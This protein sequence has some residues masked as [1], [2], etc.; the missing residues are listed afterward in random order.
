[1]LNATMLMV[2]CSWYG[3]RHPALGIDV[4]VQLAQRVALTA[5]NL[6]LQAVLRR[7][8]GR[9]A[10]TSSATATQQ[11]QQELQ[12]QERQQQQ[13]EIAQDG[14]GAGCS[15]GD[16]RSGGCAGGGGSCGP[17]VERR[18]KARSSVVYAKWEGAHAE[19]R[20]AGSA[21]GVCA[22]FAAF[23]ESEG[24]PKDAPS[25]TVA[26]CA[27]GDSATAAGGAAG[28]RAGPPAR[29]GQDGRP[30][31]L[32]EQAPAHD[33]HGV[34]T[35]QS[36]TGTTC[37]VQRR[38]AR[39]TYRPHLP[40]PAANGT[41]DWVSQ[42]HTC[43]SGAPASPRR[44]GPSRPTPRYT[45][46]CR[47]RTD[48]YK[49]PSPANPDQLPPGYERRLA[50]LFAS[51][52]Q[53]MTYAY[54][55]HGC[56]ELTVE[57]I[58]GT[59]AWGPGAGEE[60]G[61]AA[62]GGAGAA[63]AAGSG[64]GGG[65]SGAVD[66]GAGRGA[67]GGLPGWRYQ[68][69]PLIADGTAGSAGGGPDGDMPTVAEVLA[70]LRLQGWEQ[71][72]QQQQ[73]ELVQHGH[74][75]GQ[76]P[77]PGDEVQAGGRGDVGQARDT[78]RAVRHWHVSG[79]RGA[80]RQ[81]RDGAG[82]GARAG[83]GGAGETPRRRLPLE[84][85]ALDPRVIFVGERRAGQGQGQGPAVGGAPGEAGGSVCLW[86]RLVCW[87]PE[88]AA[89]AVEVA[90]GGREGAGPAAGDGG[91]RCASQGD[92]WWGCGQLE[93]VVRCQGRH[94]PCAVDVRPAG[95]WQELERWQQEEPQEQGLADGAPSRRNSW[96][97]SSSGGG[98]EEEAEVEVEAA[99]A[100]GEEQA[101]GVAGAPQE[102]QGGGEEVLLDC[103]IELPTLP[104]HD[105]M[106]VVSLPYPTTTVRRRGIPVRG[107]TFVLASAWCAS[108][109]CTPLS[110]TKLPGRPTAHTLLLPC[111]VYW[112][113]VFHRVVTLGPTSLPTTVSGACSVHFARAWV[114]YRHAVP[115]EA[116]V[117][118]GPILLAL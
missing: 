26:A 8:R 90:A 117:H 25:P 112:S 16:V 43:S 12:P 6:G 114:H 65:G 37:L 53:Y 80:A 102:Q 22:P 73:Q 109:R 52:G 115:S 36:A 82:A 66:A 13:Q 77:R 70:Q 101:G 20:P 85:R 28:G 71:Q 46:Y 86:A 103:S 18:G 57:T 96:G 9:G 68:S 35:S 84:V 93:V 113:R 83:A 118:Q 89:A 27:V 4:R 98:G 74:G 58:D 39:P 44:L 76:G 56:I 40:T 45:S 1:M 91:G 97:S 2:L 94:V 63:G 61:G 41:P 69:S 106:L 38:S 3:P 50:E 32:Q 21:A 7:R 33:S 30:E 31:R 5:F 111:A 15:G 87:R 60:G 47:T 42:S 54:V 110:L 95:Q 49:M 67:A 14:S 23:L 92:G 116:L 107:Y 24:G 108:V 99:A 64:G 81:G 104:S 17:G 105:G 75:R 29:T 48:V 79:P 62:G 34:S 11:Q 88:A 19:D 78:R 100:E 59:A 55:R 10:P 72:Q 51:R